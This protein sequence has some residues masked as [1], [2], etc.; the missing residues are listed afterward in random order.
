M[1][2]LNNQMLMNAL[3]WSYD[4]ALQGMPGTLSARE[5]ADS[6]LKKF[7]DPEKAINSLIKWQQSKCGT[8]G[9]I[10]G[11]GGVITLPVSIPANLASVL[12]VQIRMVAAIACIRGYDLKDDQVKTFVY[13]CMTGQSGSEVL[14]Q[15]GKQIGMKFGEAQ[16]KKIP[17]HALRKINQK[18]G[19]KLLTKFGEKGVVNLG[20]TIPIIGGVVGGTADTVNTFLIGKAAKKTFHNEGGDF[21][22]NLIIEM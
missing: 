1:E 18:I 22:K 12:Y 11:L 21:E 4:N 17:G 8:S 15:M 20:K 9:F 16:I 7:K 13:I 5:L 3:D 10:T 6:Y 19:F 2:K 14:K